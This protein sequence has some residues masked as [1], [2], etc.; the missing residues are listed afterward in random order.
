[1]IK[2]RHRIARSIC[3]IV[4]SLLIMGF[5]APMNIDAFA[6][7]GSISVSVASLD[8]VDS[9]DF[10][11]FTFKLYKV[12]GYKGAD[13][14]LDPEFDV[15]LPESEEDGQAWLDAAAKVANIIEH[16]AE[17]QEKRSPEK[18]FDNVKPGGDPMYYS[19][20]ENGLF[21]LI[22]NTVNYKG[23]NYTPVPMFVR[24]FNG[25]DDEYTI[26]NVD[27]MIKIL[28]EPAVLEHSVIKTWDDKENRDGVRPESI[29]VGI[30][31]GSQLID[32]IVLGGDEGKWTYKWKSLESGE[33][34][35]YIGEKNG[36][37]VIIEFTPGPD[38]KAW[39]VRE[40]TD[41]SQIKDSVAKSESK[42][43]IYYEPE[44][45]KSTSKTLE[46]FKINNPQ[47]QSPPEPPVPPE[48][49]KPHKPKTGD[50]NNLVLWGGIGIAACLALAGFAIARKKRKDEE[51]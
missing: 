42:N 43:L 21:L 40:F 23:S 27:G 33:N 16:P 18:V 8:G 36:E 15:S 28:I 35:R 19:T 5:I 11:G 49:P 6:A 25:T 51:E 10:P 31:Y 13:F 2:Q 38:D 44:Y 47:K 45:S 34:Y 32:R 1:M 4:L 29:E 37:E 24:T 26:A 12:G 50:T 39:G 9:S 46:L 3:A 30:Y 41:K 20:N 7:G 14:D 17:G 22:G 48:P